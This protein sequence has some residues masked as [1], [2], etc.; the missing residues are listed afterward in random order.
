VAR[1]DRPPDPDPYDVDVSIARN[2]VDDL[3]VGL[4]VWSYRREPD[5][6][7]RRAA[8]DAVAAIDAALAALYRVRAR[9]ITETRRADDEAAAR[10]DALLARTAAPPG[11]TRDGPAAK[12][13]PPALSDLDA[14]LGADA[15][16]SQATPGRRRGGEPEAAP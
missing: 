14:R 8:S 2:G 6:H 1:P 4:A 13:G 11:H 10:V 3:G 16:P 15:M 9:L 5:A 7:A 12:A